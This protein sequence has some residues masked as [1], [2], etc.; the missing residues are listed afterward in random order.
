MNGL[1][2]RNQLAGFFDKLRAG[3]TRVVFTNGCFDLLHPGHMKLL[4]RSSEEGDVLVVAINDDASVR[5][6]KGPSRPIYPAEERAEILLSVRWVDYVTVFPEATPLETI[7]LIRPD[8]LIKGAE[9]KQTEIIG[10]EFVKNNGGR[11]VRIPMKP[12]HSTR[13][14]VGRMAGL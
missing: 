9:Y 13:R 8:V 14:L 6:L 12:G 1:I 7:K 5:A 4:A 3:G 10:A 2:P 11:V